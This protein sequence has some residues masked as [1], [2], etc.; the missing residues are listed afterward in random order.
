MEFKKESGN[1]NNNQLS[2]NDISLVKG[3]ASVPHGALLFINQL[4][5]VNNDLVRELNDEYGYLESGPLLPMPWHKS[6]FLSH[7]FELLAGMEEY[8]YMSGYMNATPA[9]GQYAEGKCKTQS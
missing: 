2:V 9:L 3:G 1:S 8:T 6:Q 7:S 4:L 5:F